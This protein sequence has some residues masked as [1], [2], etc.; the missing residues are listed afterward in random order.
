MQSKRN[1]HM[2]IILDN[3]S[4]L[5]RAAHHYSTFQTAFITVLD[6][7]LSLHMKSFDLTVYFHLDSRESL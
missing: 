6:V 4:R 5:F 3:Y 2:H 7:F 1:L